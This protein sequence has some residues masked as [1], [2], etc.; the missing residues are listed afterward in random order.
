MNELI[1]KFFWGSK[2]SPSLS[3]GNEN[4]SDDGRGCLFTPSLLL[5]FFLQSK[6]SYHPYRHVLVTFHHPNKKIDVWVNCI[7]F[8]SFATHNIEKKLSF[9]P[10]A[11]RVREEKEL[12]RDVW[13]IKWLYTHYYYEYKERARIIC[14]KSHFF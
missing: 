11:A 10:T 4:D 7:R 1:W 3:V 12:K 2:R 6:N 5:H 9:A 8:M 13:K 14:H